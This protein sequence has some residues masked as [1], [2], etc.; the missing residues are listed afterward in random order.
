MFDAALAGDRDVAHPRHL[1]PMRLA[2]AG[3]QYASAGTELFDPPGKSLDEIVEGLTQATAKGRLPRGELLRDAG[4]LTN[5]LT[6]WLLPTRSPEGAVLLGPVTVVPEA[7]SPTVLRAQALGALRSDP[8]DAAPWLTLE[9]V[10][11]PSVLTGT[12]AE[13]F[14]AAIAKVDIS[15]LVQQLAAYARVVTARLAR[16]AVAAGLSAH[17][18]RLREALLSAIAAGREDAV[19]KQRAGPTGAT[20]VSATGRDHLSEAQLGALEALYLLAQA[21]STRLEAMSTFARDLAALGRLDIAFLRRARVVL[22]QFAGDLPLAEAHTFTS[23][24][25]EARGS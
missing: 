16:Q 20:E 15:A 11:G 10:E 17:R 8:F 6:A 25:A 2:L 7:L 13:S 24:L 3:L 4:S 1:V 12:D 19:R 18:T 9:L 22:E 14:D 5:T 23:L 21:E